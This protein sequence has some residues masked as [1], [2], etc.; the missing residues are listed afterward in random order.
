MSVAFDSVSLLSEG[1]GLQ[2]SN[3]GVWNVDV[4]HKD[5]WKHWHTQ[6]ELVT[7]TKFIEVHGMSLK[8]VNR[9]VDAVVHSLLHTS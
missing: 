7:I 6:L 8:H 3:Y 4:V 5:G 9:N 2:C 1:V